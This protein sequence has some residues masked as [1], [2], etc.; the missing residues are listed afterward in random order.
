MLWT[1]IETSLAQAFSHK[2][3]SLLLG[4]RGEQVVGHQY[5][6]SGLVQMV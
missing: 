2:A 4:G 1:E 5:R 3:E 6:V